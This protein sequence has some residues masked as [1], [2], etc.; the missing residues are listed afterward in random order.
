VT[1]GKSVKGN[2][3]IDTAA[4]L[5]PTPIGS[6]AVVPA[7]GRATGNPVSTVGPTLTTGAGV[8]GGVVTSVGGELGVGATC[9]CKGT[10]EGVTTISWVGLP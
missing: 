9:C 3:V 5:R 1:D 6:V 8:T 4:L 2:G 7:P 10:A